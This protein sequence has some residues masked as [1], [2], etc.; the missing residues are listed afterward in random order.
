MTVLSPPRPAVIDRALRDARTWCAGHTIDDRPAL[1][2]AVRVAV[3]I[4]EHVPAPPPEVIAAALLHDAPDLAPAALDVYQVLTTGYGPE[5]PRIIAALQAEH[6]ALDEP[7]PPIRV[8]DQPVLLAS[9]A[10]KIVALTSLL[11]RARATGDVT[12][13]FAQRPV[14]CGLLPHFRAFQQA[15]HPRVPASMS[16]HLDAVLARL[17]QVA[18]GILSAGVR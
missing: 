12:G 13:F 15:A 11:R 7:D 5:V 1:V 16:A 14:L 2:H 17:E 18:A 6:R 10:D 9:T 8:D 4:G 3:T